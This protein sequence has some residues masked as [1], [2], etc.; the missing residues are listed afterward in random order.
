RRLKTPETAEV[1]DPSYG[2]QLRGSH[3]LLFPLRRPHG[4]ARAP[5]HTK[6]VFSSY[7]T[8]QAPGGYGFSPRLWPSRPLF[9]W[10]E[11]SSRPVFTR[12]PANPR[13]ELVLFRAPSV[14]ALRNVL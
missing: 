14:A 1:R 3:R 8:R 5:I 7:Q 6:R 10:V 9:G 12:G 13:R 4:A 11:R 2:M